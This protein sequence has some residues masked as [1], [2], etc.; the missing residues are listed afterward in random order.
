M[1]VRTRFA[2][3]PTGF[4]HIGSVRT[5]LF[6]WLVARKHNGQF[7]LRIEDTDQER[8]VEGSIGHIME[9]LRW[10]GLTW[11]EGPDNGGIHEPYVQSARLPLYRSYAEKLITA[12]FAYPDPY[13]TDELEEL[14]KKAE[15]EKRPFL[16]R[17]HRPET[18]EEWDG[19]KP[20]R[21]K[22]PF[23]KRY[24]WNDLVRGELSAGEEA[25]DDFILIKSDGFPTYNFAH[26]VD[27]IE[28]KIT[29]VMRG[30]EFISSTPKF[31]SLYDAL[32]TQPPAF[33]T[34]PVILGPDGKKKLSK[35]DGAK[36]LLMYR[37][38]GYLP[39]AFL[40]FLALLGWNPGTEQ[41]Y[42]T[43]DE[44]IAA[45]DLGQ[46]QK[47]GANLNETKLLSVN[48]HW[49]RTLSPQIYIER[50][51]L[52]APDQ[53]RLLKAVPL[54]QERAHTFD[55]ARYLLDGELSCLFA[56]PTL[57]KGA[58]IAKGSDDA[59]EFTR[60]ALQKVLEITATLSH[61]ITADDARD[62]I[63][64]YA[65]QNPKE[66]GGRG[67]VLWPLRYAL[68]GL[69]RSPDPFTLI[70]ILGPQESGLRIEAALAILD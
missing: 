18:I 12:G 70:S 7:I 69:E 67:A 22:V 36:D 64:P 65:D 39:E 51:N 24:A 58:L 9:S 50:G 48:Q 35:R 11:D 53:E 32:E 41:E 5:A 52:T 44:L 68:S 33:A 25:L 30:D 34:L 57:D 1:I 6:A 16:F 59:A 20:L 10:L 55:E 2:P 3:S 47:S 4:M 17:D 29:H 45:F 66:N 28:M 43:I 15:A 61:S 40:N 56:K 21:F 37:T 19:R 42:F 14:R 46:V 54:M 63:M 26:I 38:E 62:A 60:E 8:E 49:M 13:T 23:L 27:D 31:L